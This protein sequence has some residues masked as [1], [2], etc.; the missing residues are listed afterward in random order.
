MTRRTVLSCLLAFSLCSAETA[1]RDFFWEAPETVS[2]RDSRFPSSSTNGTVS[3]IVWQDIEPEGKDSGRIWLSGRVF[4]GKRWFDRERFAG[5]FVYA[6]EVPSIASVTVNGKGRII[7][8][9]ASGVNSVTVLSSDDFGS[10]FASTVIDGGGTGLLAPRVFVR[11]DGGYLLFATYGTEN[12]FVMVMSRSDDGTAWPALTPFGPTS[13]RRRA[14]LPSHAAINGQDIVVFQ[15]F[16]DETGRSS[17]QLYST[18]SRDR[19]RSW[20]SP[21]LITNF[22]DP[23]APSS[24]VYTGYHNQRAKMLAVKGVISLVWERARTANEKYAIYHANVGADGKISGPVERIS[25]DEGYCY[26]P[27]IIELSGSPAVAWFDNRR[28]VNSVYLARKEGFLWSESDLSKSSIDSVFG[29]LLPVD[30]TVETYWQQN[31]GRGQYRIVRLAPDRTAPSPQIL[32]VG[33][34]SGDAGRGEIV[35]FNLRLPEDSSGTAGYSLAWARGTR[36]EV[37]KTVQSLPSETRVTKSADEDG[38]WYLG[39]RLVDYAGNW[40]DPVYAEYVKDTTPPAAPVV[41]AGIPDEKG[42]LESNTFSLKWAPAESDRIAG[43][44]WNL[45]Y[46]APLPEVRSKADPSGRVDPAE[47]ARG[48]TPSP[49]PPVIRSKEPVA[50]FENQDNGLYA[51]SVAAVDSVGNVGEPTVKYIALDKYKPVTRIDAVDLSKD[52]TG[53]ISV[54]IVGR[55]F[56]EEGL[57]GDI[58]VDRDGVAPWD[59]TLTRSSGNF[60]VVNDRLITGLVVADLDEGSYRV[61]IS[62][63]A[64]GLYAS[65]PILAVSETGTVKLG[66]YR[67]AFAPPWERTAGARR[68]PLDAGRLLTLSLL[69]FAILVLVASA[70]GVSLAARDTLVVR[71]EVRALLTGDIMP[72]ERKRRAAALRQKGLGL[73]FKLAFFT[74]T[75]V[76]SVVLIVSIPLGVRFSANQERMLARGLESRVNVLLESLSSGA[77]AYLPSQNLLELG[78]LPSQMSALDEATYAT[79]TG[80]GAGGGVAGIDFV[81]ASNDPDLLSRI[82]TERLEPGLSAL[83]GGENDEINSRIAVLNSEAEQAVGELSKGI[84]ALTQEGR[85]LALKVDADSVRRRDEIQVITRQLEE[86]LA[87]ELSRLSVKG[88]GSWPEYDPDALSRGNTRYVFYKPVLYRSGT[89]SNYVNGTVRVGV[90]TD[91]LLAAMDQDRKALVQTTAYIALFAVLMG[92]IGALILASIIISP[93]RKLASHVAMIRDTEDK[94]ALDGKEI[95]LRSRD[96]IGLLGDTINDMTRGLVRAAAASKDLTVGKEVQKMFIPLETDSDGRKLSSGSTSDDHAEFFGYY[97]GAKGVSGDY[98]D[99]IKLDDRHYAIIK[100]DV[101]GKGVPAALIMVEVATLFLDY[102]KDWKYEKNG[103]KL[104]YIV[105]RINDLI[106]SRGFKGRFA[107]FTLCILDS[108]SGAVHF[109]NAGDNLIHTYCAAERKMKVLA[110]KESSAAGVF[111]TFMVD[112][113]GGF[114]V[115]TLKLAPGDVL[116]LYTDGIEEAKR[117][118]RT[119]DLQVLTCAEPGLAQEAAHGNHSVGQDNEEL[120]PERVN[121]IIEAVFAHSVFTLEKWHNPEGAVR[122]EFDFSSCEG[123]LEEA[124]LALVSVEKVFRMYADPSATDFDRVQ[125]DRK[126]DGFLSRHFRQYGMY[127]SS[128]RDHPELGEYLYYTRVRE[129]DQYDDLTILAVRKKG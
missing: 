114:A 32:P 74:T 104:G 110:L 10:S 72:S 3:A 56:S 80:V 7:V 9:V 107:A 97:E 27:D 63:P 36:P 62:H 122:Y 20:S 93:V 24:I 70:R 109:C 67:Y 38:P 112:M 120:G 50:T 106:E 128:R 102:F 26:D 127:C 111:P 25:S 30:D 34:A 49:P 99:Y 5:P 15:A 85:S 75:L 101:A 119:P 126:I 28:G 17:Y 23:G 116:F 21:A 76:I 82:D 86:R 94:E 100:C 42:F 121:A 96:E 69:L 87:T 113:K 108:V 68:S 12:N 19:G 46:V 37:P 22:T 16:H 84:V 129:D 66:D 44:T 115:E 6:G 13:S 59:M 92:V 18:V 2:S 4:D 58:H 54:S 51:L 105:S 78:F 33:F 77:R 14:F 29:R 90:S 43:Y 83:S 57:V 65:K 52:E 124:I 8:P 88:A 39:V 91:S 47:A 41:F 123:T 60:R 1:A 81:W 53:N 31:L 98:F 79:I 61:V 64:R 103:Y 125:V 71:D 35:R 89:S 55:G 48:F 11:S 95:A 73:R 117:L 40:S 118:F 45:E